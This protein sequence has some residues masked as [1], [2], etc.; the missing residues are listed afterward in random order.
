MDFQKLFLKKVSEIRSKNVMTFPVLTISLLKQ[1]GKFKDEEFA[2][3]ACEH[4]RKWNDS[5]F[6]VD[7]SVTSLSNCCRLKS[8]VSDLYF[9]SIGGT[10]LSVGSVKVN[11]INLAHIALATQNEKEYLTKL[12][13]ITEID[14]Q[15]LDVVRGIIVRNAEKGLLPIITLKMMDLT[16]SYNSIGVLGIYETMKTFGYTKEDE[17][18]NVYYTPEA[19]AFGKKIFDVIHNTKNLFELDKDYRI[20]LEAVPAESAASKLQK[21]DKLLYP[22]TVVDDLPLYGNQFIPLGIKTTLQERIRIAALFD[23]YCNGGS[24]LH[25]CVDAPF[26]TPEKAWE[27]LNYV[28]DQGVTYFAF[29]GKIQACERNHGFYGKTCPECGGKVVTEYSR[30]VGFFVPTRT[31]SKARR[32]EWSMRQWEDLN[33][34]IISS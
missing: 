26:D 13:E 17:F 3:W 2:R 18:G 28:S 10:A 32:E 22:N 23:S 25:I 12:K 24:I 20:N 14:L 21:K 33:G 9:N 8:D 31:Y 29:T 30:I 19:E 7:S 4:N 1:N 15:C 27:M 11:T 34:P 6:F 5:N 16:H